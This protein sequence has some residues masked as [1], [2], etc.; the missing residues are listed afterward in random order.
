MTRPERERERS[1]DA[2]IK[3]EEGG[4]GGGGEEQEAV[5]ASRASINSPFGPKDTRAASG[6]VDGAPSLWKGR[7]YNLI[8]EPLSLCDDGNRMKKEDIDELDGRE[9]ERGRTSWDGPGR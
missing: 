3:T 2:V 7:R 6:V 4:I 1:I 9:R 8:S 5:C